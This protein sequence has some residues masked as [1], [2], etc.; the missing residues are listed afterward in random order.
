MPAAPKLQILTIEGL[1][2]PNGPKLVLPLFATD[3]TFKRA[4]RQR[5]TR[6]KK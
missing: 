4:E 5:K 3:G 6:K 2:D 1:F